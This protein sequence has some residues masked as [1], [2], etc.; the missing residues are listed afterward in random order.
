MAQALVVALFHQVLLYHPLV[1]LPSLREAEHQEAL[2][3]A[4]RR[5][6]HRVLK[7]ASSRCFLPLAQVDVA[8]A[9]AVPP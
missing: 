6:F 2:S 7:R 8:V 4:H 5:V 3:H 1:A 9:A